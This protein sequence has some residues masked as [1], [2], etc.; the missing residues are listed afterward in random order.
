MEVSGVALAEHQPKTDTT[1]PF[2]DEVH[3]LPPCVVAGGAL[4]QAQ[5]A[6]A[7]AAELL[8]IQFVLDVPQKVTLAG[9]AAA[10][11]KLKV[12][13]LCSNGLDLVLQWGG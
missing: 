13:A 12:P 7:E 4:D 10:Q 6:L 5:L 9:R 2:E 11:Q 3:E 1:Y 8:Q